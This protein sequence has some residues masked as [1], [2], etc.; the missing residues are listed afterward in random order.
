MEAQW[1]KAARNEG[2]SNCIEV[3]SDLSAVRD[4]KI[5]PDR[6]SKRPD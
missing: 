5:R 3:C 6:C 1:K 4:S 2:A